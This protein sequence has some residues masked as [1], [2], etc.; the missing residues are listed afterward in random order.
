LWEQA[1]AVTGTEAGSDIHDS[2]YDGV[3][4]NNGGVKEN[5]TEKARRPLS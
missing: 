3:K 2:H 1:L 4:E 5:K